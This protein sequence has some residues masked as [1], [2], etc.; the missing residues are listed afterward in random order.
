MDAPLFPQRKANR[1]SA[2]DYSACGAYF[3]TVCTAPR[4]NHFWL[5]GYENSWGKE[6]GGDAV[7][8]DM[9]R[10]PVLSDAGKTAEAAILAIPDHYRGIDV[11]RYCV[12]PD[13]LHLLLLFLSDEDGRMISAPTL[14]RVIGSMKRWVSRQL[15]Y[16]V[17]QKSFYDRV[18]RSEKGYLAACRYID[19]NPARWREDHGDDGAA[20][21]DDLFMDS[22]PGI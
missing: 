2:F 14:S 13:H 10:P 9:I 5:P 21:D 22:L 12:M 11:A 8:A 6:D 3:V 15:G 18:V 17:W 16:A 7:G 1:L 4:K 20:F 19:E